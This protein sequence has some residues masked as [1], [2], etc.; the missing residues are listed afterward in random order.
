MIAESKRQWKKDDTS[1]KQAGSRKKRAGSKHKPKSPK[2]LKVIKEQE[3]TED[4]QEKEELILCL[5]IVQDEDRSINYE[6]LAMKS[7][8]IDWETQLL[9]SDLQ[10]ED[11]NYSKITKA[12]GSFRFYKVFLTMLKEFDR[13]DLFDL[14]RLVIKRFESIA[15]EGYD[16]LG[17][18]EDND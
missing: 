11:L 5:K 7:L 12:D 2:K 10:G 4:E 3:S 8:I 13:Q 17:R 6:T 16:S 1:G 15:L 18:F 9:G 14:Y